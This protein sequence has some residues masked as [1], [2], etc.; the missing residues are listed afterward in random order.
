MAQGVSVAPVVVGMREKLLPD[1]PVVQPNHADA[2][3][4]VSGPAVL[5]DGLTGNAS[6]TVVAEVA[7]DRPD[8]VGALIEDS[9]VT[10]SG[11]GVA[12]PLV[13]LAYARRVHRP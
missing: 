7:N 10:G 2:A 12:G 4:R 11:H 8:R 1:R 5:D 6:P 13:D 3:D 9:A